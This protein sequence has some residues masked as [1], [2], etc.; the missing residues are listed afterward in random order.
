M[1]FWRFWKARVSTAIRSFHVYSGQREEFSK[2]K[3]K[4]GQD[5][6]EM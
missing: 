3:Y 2:S 6:K 4:K 1:A 5:I